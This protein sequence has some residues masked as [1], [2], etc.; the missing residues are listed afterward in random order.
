[1]LLWH[2]TTTLVEFDALTSTDEFF[3][4]KPSLGMYTQLEASMASNTVIEPWLLVT[5]YT[6]KLLVEAPKLDCRRTQYIIQLL[7]VIVVKVMGDGDW[8]DGDVSEVEV[9]G[10]DVVAIR[11]PF[12]LG[13]PGE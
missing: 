10:S 7:V 13:Y 12:Q 8:M 9:R 4:C 2:T 11:T 5:I 3:E 6:I 1:M